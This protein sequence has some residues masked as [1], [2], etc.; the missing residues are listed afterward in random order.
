MAPVIRLATVRDAPELARLLTQL[1]HP[2]DAARVERC[3]DAWSAEGNAAYVAEGE[4]GALAGVLTTHRMVVLHRPKPVGRVT[5]LVVEESLRGRGIG[6]ALMAAAEQALRDS[7]C[8]L[9]EITSNVK[10]ADA[11][12]FYESLGYERTSVRLART[13]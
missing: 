4:G 1:G 9:V 6:R 2:T 7:G 3:W 11:H 13:L 10:R 12:A 5:S 8:G